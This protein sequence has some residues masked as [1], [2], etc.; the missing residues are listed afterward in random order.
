M[1]RVTRIFLNKRSSPGLRTRLYRLN[2]LSF[3]T[4]CKAGN[5]INRRTTKGQEVIEK[6]DVEKSA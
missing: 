4:L 6:E 1:A 3:D 5:L 2:G